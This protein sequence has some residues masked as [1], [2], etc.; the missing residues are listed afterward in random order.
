M[1]KAGASLSVGQNQELSKS[2]VDLYKMMLCRNDEKSRTFI[3]LL[4]TPLVLPMEKEAVKGRSDAK[5][6]FPVGYI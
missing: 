6:I 3:K 1:A 2:L 4:G 5:M